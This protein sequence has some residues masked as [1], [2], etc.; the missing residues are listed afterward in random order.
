MHDL[1][2][3][4]AHLSYD[5]AISVASYMSLAAPFMVSSS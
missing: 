2:F 3:E 1:S 5:L 4:K